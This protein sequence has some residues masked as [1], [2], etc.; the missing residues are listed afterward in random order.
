MP[1][2][3]LPFPPPMTEMIGLLGFGIYV[4]AY[5]LLTLSVVTS[6]QTSYFAM[7]L[8]AA[9]CVLVGLSASFNLAAA[10]IQVFWVA[11]SLVA[12]G[13]RLTRGAIPRAAR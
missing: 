12:I 2:D 1:F 11:V 8:C 4:L 7:N 9:T 13:L 3:I 5:T 6:A 10:L